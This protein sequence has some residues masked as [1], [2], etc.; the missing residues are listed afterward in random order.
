[1]TRPHSI[2]TLTAKREKLIAEIRRLDAAIKSEKAREENER[3]KEIIDALKS[4]GLLDQPL[5]KLLETLAGAA[6]KTT[7]SQA[8]EDEALQQ[9]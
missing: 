8:N 7:S 3:Q 6:Q 4:R 5:E 1:M 9:L 2:E